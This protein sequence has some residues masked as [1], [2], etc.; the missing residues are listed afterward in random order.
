[1]QRRV[2]RSASI[3]VG[4][5]RQATGPAEEVGVG[6]SSTN[7]DED[8]AVLLVEDDRSLAR[9]LVTALT[10]HGMVVTHVLTG[11][12]AL[13][14]TSGQSVVLLDLTLPDLD[15]TEVCRRLRSISAVPIV[16]LSARA[17]ET[18]RVEALDLGADDFLVKPFGLRELIAR[19]HAVH[20]R[21]AG[22]EDRLVLRLAGLELDR[23]RHEAILD[24]ERL[25]LSSKEFDLL[26]YLLE[27]P[28]TVLP[29]RQILDHVWHGGWHGDGRTLDVHVG[30]LRKKLGDPSWIVTVRGTGFRLEGPSA[31]DRPRR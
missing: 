14:T 19:I 15:G 7:D 20:R 12:E 2:N 9:E 8:L 29:R 25:Q 16:V 11:R 1:M 18:D 24:G 10:R 26:A 27:S 13:R 17:G 21:A 4:R 30:S 22:H 6:R 3:L 28:G 5:D 23:R 31:V